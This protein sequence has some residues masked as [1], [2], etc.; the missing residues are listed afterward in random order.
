MKIN[1]EVVRMSGVLKMGVVE[2]SY[3]VRTYSSVISGGIFII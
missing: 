1:I 2:S 3:N